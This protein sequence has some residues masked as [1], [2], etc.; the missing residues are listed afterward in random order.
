MV[1]VF[2][3]W[4]R[5]RDGAQS[6]PETERVPI[7]QGGEVVYDTVAHTKDIH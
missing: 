1:F 5:W 3:D 7:D 4:G 2:Q 6:E